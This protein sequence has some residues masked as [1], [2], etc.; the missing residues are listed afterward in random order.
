[1][2]GCLA[3]LALCGAVAAFP[4]QAKEKARSKLHA[5]GK[6]A[7]ARQAT[8]VDADGYRL[9]SP[10]ATLRC[11]QTLQSTLECRD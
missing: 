9:V 6:P 7:I 11:R 1:M 8:L 2:L 5:G 3:V 4:A 10:N